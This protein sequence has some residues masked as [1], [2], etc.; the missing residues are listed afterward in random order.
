MGALSIMFAL[1]NCQKE[2]AWTPDSD[3]RRKFCGLLW[4]VCESAAAWPTTLVSCDVYIHM[5]RSQLELKRARC[6]ISNK[7]YLSLNI[8]VIFYHSMVIRS[9]D[10]TTIPTDLSET[11][12]GRF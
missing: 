5:T 6:K 2:N 11:L 3:L 10:I 7:G 12:F 8:W 9:L 4:Y 1:V